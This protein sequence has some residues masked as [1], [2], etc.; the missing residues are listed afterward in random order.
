MHI[1][2]SL[3]NCSPATSICCRMQNISG[4]VLFLVG[5]MVP[6][7]CHPFI[8]CDASEDKPLLTEEQPMVFFIR[9]KLNSCHSVDLHNSHYKIVC[10]IQSINGRQHIY[11]SLPSIK[12]HNKHQKLLLASCFDGFICAVHL[13]ACLRWKATVVCISEAWWAHSQHTSPRHWIIHHSKCV[14]WRP[15]PAHCLVFPKS[16]QIHLTCPRI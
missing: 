10:I 6:P 11:E 4:H 5:G 8:Q 12:G 1:V 2:F 9:R 13:W 14:R 16:K 15:E 3:G 7:T